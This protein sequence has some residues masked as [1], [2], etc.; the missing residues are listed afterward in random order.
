MDKSK[1][2]NILTVS[3][4]AE[5][6]A[7]KTFINNFYKKEFDYIVFEKG[8]NF[9]IFFDYFLERIRE[10]IDSIDTEST[11]ILEYE[12]KFI[13]NIVKGFVST[14]ILLGKI[15]NIKTSVDIDIKNK[16][17][18]YWDMLLH[19]FEEIGVHCHEGNYKRR[20]NK[21][22]I[23]EFINFDIDSG[24]KFETI[25][26]KEKSDE[27]TINFLSRA[28]KLSYFSEYISEFY[29]HYSYLECVTDDYEREDPELNTTDAK[30]ISCFCYTSKINADLYKMY[31]RIKSHNSKDEK[32]TFEQK[33]YLF[34]FLFLKDLDTK[35]FESKLYK[36]YID[37]LSQ[38]TES[39]E[40]KRIKIDDLESAGKDIENRKKHQKKF[41]FF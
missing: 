36:S 26:D 25:I 39:T 10:N 20:M 3:P 37:R 16:L 27:I 41:L 5:T 12:P 6:E 8:S 19:Y 2:Q 23:N 35:I 30:K 21:R 34:L 29:K 1:K 9:N 17:Q 32:C 18:N 28:G 22:L 33:L 31:S 38:K 4:Q 15:D 24:K 7:A 40:G 11:K 13:F 14:S